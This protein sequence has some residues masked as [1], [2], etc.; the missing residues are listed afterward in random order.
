MKKI[1]TAMLALGL[2]LVFSS[3]FNDREVLFEETQIEFENA[4]TLARATGEVFPIINLTRT[5]GTPNYQ[6]NLIG[7]HL[8]SAAQINFSVEEV[9]D[10]LLNANTIRAVEGVHYT[11]SG[12]TFSFPGN[13]STTSFNGL[14]IVSG[15]PAQTG[16]TALL[17]I[18]LDGN[19]SIEPAENFRR[20]G[21]SINLN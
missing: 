9:P 13:A 12:N 7:R 11:L 10:R 6:V 1:K 15:F 14:S 5:S 3:C 16:K 4:V 17:I 21:F 19:E 20:L 2:A 18:K 8:S